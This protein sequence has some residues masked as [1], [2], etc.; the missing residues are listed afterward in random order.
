MGDGCSKEL[1]D[2]GKEDSGLD[3]DRRILVEGGSFVED[4]TNGVSA[5]IVD[6]T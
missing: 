2:D 5:Y 3:T 4:N 6:T 1:A